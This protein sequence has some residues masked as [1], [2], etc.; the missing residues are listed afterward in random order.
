VRRCAVVLLG[1][2]RRR[3]I[4]AVVGVAEFGVRGA[5]P[6]A[7]GQTAAVLLAGAGLALFVCGA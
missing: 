6:L 2:W 5:L 3:W 7:L 1:W 4:A